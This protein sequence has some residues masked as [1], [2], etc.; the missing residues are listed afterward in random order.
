MSQRQAKSELCHRP[1]LGILSAKVHAI[2][3]PSEC[4]SSFCPISYGANFFIR[5]RNQMLPFIPCELCGRNRCRT[6]KKKRTAILISVVNN[7]REYILRICL[8]FPPPEEFLQHLLLLVYPSI[9]RADKSSSTCLPL[10]M[11][12]PSGVYPV[13]LIPRKP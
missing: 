1:L 2:M 3:A 9:A 12:P 10:T 5:C 11:A 8:R 6:K 7:K 13:S 4:Q